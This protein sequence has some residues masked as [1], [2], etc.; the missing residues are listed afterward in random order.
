[1]EHIR[2]DQ[3]NLRPETSNCHDFDESVIK[4]K[5]MWTAK[6]GSSGWSQWG[7]QPDIGVQSL[8]SAV[9][10]VK[11]NAYINQNVHL[12]RFYFEINSCLCQAAVAKK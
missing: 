9:T 5:L 2:E 7:L 12:T 8:I 11:T 10:G 6:G 4:N 1:M 3:L